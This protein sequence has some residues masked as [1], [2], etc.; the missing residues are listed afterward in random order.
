MM[1]FNVLNAA[2]WGDMAKEKEK[3]F[4]DFE[5]I[6]WRPGHGKQPLSLYLLLYV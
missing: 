6:T 3:S 4:F 2:T 1:M 5:F